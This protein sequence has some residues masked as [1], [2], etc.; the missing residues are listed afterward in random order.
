MS[1]MYYV[2]FTMSILT[3][4][5]IYTIYIQITKGRLAL[6]TWQGIYL[7]E[8]RNQGGWGGGHA[9]NIVITLQGQTK[10]DLV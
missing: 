1:I 3:I 6:G 9:R 2:L 5:L 10:V 7:N 8:H 4:T